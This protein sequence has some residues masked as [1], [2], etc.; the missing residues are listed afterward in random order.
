[1]LKRT[2]IFDATTSETELRNELADD[3]V[4]KPR[5]TRTTQLNK[6]ILRTATSRNRSIDHDAEHLQRQK[7]EAVGQL[8]SGIAHDF[9]NLLTIISGNLEML[10]LDRSHNRREERVLVAEA[11]RVTDLMAQLTTNLLAFARQGQID[12]I[13]TD[14]GQLATTTARFLSRILGERIGLE[15]QAVT[16]LNAKINAAQFQTVL[17][18]LAANAR[19]AMPEGGRVAIQVD[20]AFVGAEEARKMHV[21][22]GRYATV[23]VTDNGPGMRKE[24]LGHAFDLFFTTKPACNGLGLAAVR[25][26]AANVGGTTRIRSKLGNGTTVELWIPVEDGSSQPLERDFPDTR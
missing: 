8:A 4:R 22:S 1:M 5:K 15:I 16:G 20:E 25:E 24:T 12:C 6:P 2:D 21:T 26:F 3:L 14:I 7:M 19:D 11:W 18:N 13:P 9:R 23:S 10:A 17:I